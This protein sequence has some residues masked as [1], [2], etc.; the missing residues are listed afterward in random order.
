MGRDRGGAAALRRTD[1]GVL[2][3][4]ARADLVVLDAPS[5]IHLAY[6]PGFRSDTSAQRRSPNERKQLDRRR[7]QGSGHRPV[8]DDVLAVARPPVPGWTSR[9]DGAR[10][11]CG[12]PRPSW[13]TSNAGRPVYGVSTGFGALA[14]RHPHER[15]AQAA[16]QR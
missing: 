5:Y 12:Q 10:R 2:A 7:V 4:G 11:R 6:R 15:R 9:P 16:A 8:T 14:T 3:P 1:I 13:T